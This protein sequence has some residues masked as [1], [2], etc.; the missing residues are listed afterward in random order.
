MIDGTKEWKE[1]QIRKEKEVK[2]KGKVNINN[3]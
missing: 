3:E 2:E 1:I